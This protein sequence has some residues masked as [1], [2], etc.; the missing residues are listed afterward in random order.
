MQH[1][2]QPN[3]VDSIPEDRDPGLKD[4]MTHKHL[5]P[6]EELEE[7]IAELAAHIDAATWRLL[8]AVSEFDRREGWAGGF[9]SCAHWLSWRTGIDKVT[10]RQKVR[11]ARALDTLPKISDELRQGKISYSKVRAMVRI[12]TPENE[13]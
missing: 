6:L 3:P 7:E 9:L 2:V 1:F 12:A 13:E 8:K 11:V 4:S 10:A 5:R